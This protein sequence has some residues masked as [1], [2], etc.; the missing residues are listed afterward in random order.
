[1]STTTASSLLTI[2]LITSNDPFPIAN[3]I[4]VAPFWGD[5]DTRKAGTV[6]YT[7]PVS[8]DSVSLERAKEVINTM[9]DEC[10]IFFSQIH[11]HS[12]LGSCAIFQGAE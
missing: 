1:M 7:N 10:N 12:H 3:Y 11:G 2:P 9:D 6:W 4:L 5:V 8:N